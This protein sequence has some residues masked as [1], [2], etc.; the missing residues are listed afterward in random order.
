MVPALAAPNR[1]AIVTIIEQSDKY[2]AV[3]YDDGR[4]SLERRVAGRWLKLADVERVNLLWIRRFV[5]G[6]P[7]G[8][9]AA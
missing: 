3:R 4:V 2:R 5:Y 8:P 9:E 1:D 7:D 6:T